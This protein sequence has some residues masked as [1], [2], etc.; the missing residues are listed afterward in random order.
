MEPGRYRGW[1]YTMPHPGIALLTFNTPERMNG[2]TQQ[3][4]RDLTEM[5]LQLE[6]DDRVRVIVFTGSGRAFSAGDDI[7]G[8][9]AD[10]G[11]AITLTPDLPR[12]QTPVERVASLRL[13]SQHINW[14]I[15][16]I[17]KPTIAAINGVAIQSGFSLALACDY[18][19][20]AATARVGS[21]T[22]RWA[23][24]PD[25][26][27]HYLLVQL[28]GVAKA[29]DFLMRNRIVTA[30]EALALGLVNEVVEP[31]A[32]LERTLTLARELADGPQVAMRLLKRAIYNAAHLTMEQ[33]GEDIA[34]RTG[35]S[36]HHADATEGV[37]AFREKRGAKF[38]A[39]LP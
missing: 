5:M 23:Y 10:Y 32:L 34:L 7:T 14:A 1:E 39:W 21:A 4:K 25:E 28:L 17:D 33:A 15:R 8:R 2:M 19:L 30:P 20:A 9:T 27:G 37:T 11:D 35:I 22:L 26:N 29:W 6:M 16:N 13:R 12:G 24:Q 31:E 3:V 18:R 36:D 38:N